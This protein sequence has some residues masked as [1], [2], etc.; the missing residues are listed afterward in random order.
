MSSVNS[1]HLVGNLCND[2]ELRYTSSGRPCT[3]VRLATT[4]RWTDPDGNRKESTNFHRITIWG[5]LAESCAQHLSKGRQV[6][7][8]GYLQN[9]QYED[10]EGVTRYVSEVVA[11]NVQFLGSS[12]KKQEELPLEGEQPPKDDDLEIPEDEK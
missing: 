6:Y 10:R 4:R 1:V 8:E 3:N 2:V 9:R 7:I 12:Q 11:R 5:K